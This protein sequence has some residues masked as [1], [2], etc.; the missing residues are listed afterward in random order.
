MSR[1]PAPSEIDT[2]THCK[3]PIHGKAA[4]QVEGT[5]GPRTVVPGRAEFGRALH[6]TK[7]IWAAEAAALMMDYR[8]LM[9]WDR[10]L[11]GPGWAPLV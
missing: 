3:T 5:A 7:P 9:I 2:S 4:R 6:E 11:P 8:L 10:S 1:R